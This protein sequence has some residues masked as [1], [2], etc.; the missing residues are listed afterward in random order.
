[1]TFI[2]DALNK[3]IIIQKAV[4]DPNSAGGYSRSYED[5][6]TVWG[7]LKP[8]AY[9]TYIRGKQIDENNTHESIFRKI[10]FIELNREW[11]TGFGEGF[12]T[13]TDLNDLKSEYFLFYKKDDSGKGRRFRIN[14]AKNN[15]EDDEYISI[16]SEEIEEIGTGY[17]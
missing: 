6:L 3:R 15:D 1:M 11:S 7:S 10:A 16:L 5:L 14:N 17:P 9:G 13:I 12:D 4:Q 8:I 2:A